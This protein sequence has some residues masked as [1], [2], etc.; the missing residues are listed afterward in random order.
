M[1][2]IGEP[3]TEETLLTINEFC[4]TLRKMLTNEALKVSGAQKDVINQ[5][6]TGKELGLSEHLAKAFNALN[7]AAFYISVA[8]NHVN[9]AKEHY[10]KHKNRESPNTAC[11]GGVDGNV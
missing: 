11:D 6:M 5:G 4:S 3:L 7:E 9:Y 10:G 1:G 8:E 2:T